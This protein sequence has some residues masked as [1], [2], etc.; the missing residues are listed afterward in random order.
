VYLGVLLHQYLLVDVVRYQNNMLS[1]TNAGVSGGAVIHGFDARWGHW[2][3]SLSYSW[4]HYGL[5]IDSASN[6]NECQGYL[7][8]DKGGRCLGLTT[9]LPSC[10]GC[11]EILGASNSWTRKS[12][13][14]PVWGLLYLCFICRYCRLCPS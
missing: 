4:P 2:D 12:L 8:G 3:F 7:V 11:L 5:G 13:S 14:R 10:A 6:R 1:T 9:L